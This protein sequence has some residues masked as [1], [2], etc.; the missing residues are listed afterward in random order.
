MF[1]KI[2]RNFDKD[3]PSG[4][5][6]PYRR[7]EDANGYFPFA[8]DGRTFRI[9]EGYEAVSGAGSDPEVWEVL[10]VDEDGY[11]SVVKF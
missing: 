9:R 10:A 8:W 4:W 7:I 5:F 1:M 11:P 2:I 3:G 6:C